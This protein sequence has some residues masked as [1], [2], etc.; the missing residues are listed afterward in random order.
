VSDEPT[1]G[2]T[3]TIRDQVPAGLTPT[4]A[5]GSGLTCTGGRTRTDVLAAHTSYPPVE[6][7]V[8]VA[9]DA[10]ASITNSPTVTG[11]GGNVWVDGTSD[12]V[13]IAR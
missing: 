11:Q 12:Q 1:D 4:A 3:I 10:P 2:S 7:T 13:V 5:S 8:D 6:V 9:A